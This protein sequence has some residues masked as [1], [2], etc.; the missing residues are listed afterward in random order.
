MSSFLH[1][2]IS[3]ILGCCVAAVAVNKATENLTAVVVKKHLVDMTFNLHM[4]KYC[5]VT[6]CRQ[7]N[8]CCCVYRSSPTW[9]RVRLLGTCVWWTCIQSAACPPMHVVFLTPS[10]DL[11]P[12]WAQHKI[13]PTGNEHCHS[14][15]VHIV[16][17]LPIQAQWAFCALAS[18][19]VICHGFT[20]EMNQGWPVACFKQNLF[21]SVSVS[22]EKTR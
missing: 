6:L 20:M 16:C 21:P 15:C 17:C 19:E 11:E 12:L 10:S 22:E 3:K 5:P 1:I 14:I 18:G 9:Q 4:Q 7:N 13:F 8:L 2:G